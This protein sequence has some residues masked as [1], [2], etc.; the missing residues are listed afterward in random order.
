MSTPGKATVPKAQRPSAGKVSRI[1]QTAKRKPVKPR[2]PE[3]EVAAMMKG[4]GD[5]GAP[6]RET[7]TLLSDMLADFIV[8]VVKQASTRRTACNCMP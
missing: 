4:F 5:D 3:T 8:R 2:L 7:V 6:M 1:I